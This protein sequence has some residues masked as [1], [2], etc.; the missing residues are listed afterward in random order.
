[1][2]NLDEATLEPIPDLSHI[3][4]K[5]PLPVGRDFL[6]IEERENAIPKNFTAPNARSRKRKNYRNRTRKN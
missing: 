5:I 1:M 4:G 2:T 3:I 6:T